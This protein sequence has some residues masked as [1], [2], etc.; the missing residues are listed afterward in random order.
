MKNWNIGN[1]LI[2]LIVLSSLIGLLLAI[3]LF[4][5]SLKDIEEHVY[6]DTI[7]HLN[8]TVSQRVEAKSKI[9]LSNAVSIA[10]DIGVINALKNKDREMAIEAM[11]HLSQKFKDNTPFKNI[12]VHIHDENGNSFLRSWAP[13]KFGDPLRDVRRT[14][15][16]VYTTKKALVGTEAGRLNT[17]L[18]G[19]APVTD[20]NGNYLGSIEFKAGFNSIIKSI[21]KFD[22]AH[23]LMLLNKETIKASFNDDKFK[24]LKQVHGMILNQKS[25]DE[26][27][28]NY[29][30]TLDFEQL[31]NNKYTLDDKYF[32]TFAPV[33]DYSGKTI[34]MYLIGEESQH[35]EEL[36]NQ[37]QSIVY[38]AIGLMFIILIIITLIIST[39]SRKIIINPL[40][41]LNKAIDNVKSNSSGSQRI[42]V[43]RN[44]EIGKVA[45]N[46]NSYLQMIEDGIKQDGKVIDEAIEIVHKAKEGFYTYQI[47]QK[48][49]SPQVDKL[50]V[51]V[52]E[53]LKVTSKNLELIITA[54]IQFGNA[55]YDYTINATSSG[56]I[57]SLIKGTNALGVSVSEVLNMV[58]NTAQRLSANAEQLAA[59]SEELSA[60]STEQAASLEETAAAIEQIT[61]TIVQ[62]DERTRKMLEIAHELQNTS[63][64]DDELA[65]KTGASMEEIDKATN[66]IV[67]AISII[68][69]IA[70]QT[71]ILSLNAAVEAATAG[72]AGKGFAVV[73]QEVRNLASRSAEAANDIKKLVTYAQEKTKE[74]K[75]TAD[76]MVESFN[77]LNEKVSEVTSNVQQVTEATHEQK[78]GMEQIN[79]AVN[80]LDK[81]TQENAN[82][83]EIV[84]NKAMALSEIS[85][86]LIAIV[87]R[88]SFDKSR[89]EG[90]CDVNLVFDT[91]KLKLDHISFKETN[92]KELGNGQT[93]KVKSHHECDL[94][95]WIEQHANE[96]YTQNSD[97]TNF[98]KAHE[99][100]HTG[101]QEFIHI[102]AKDRNDHR[103]YDLAHKIEDSTLKVFEGIDK[104]KAHKCKESQLERTRDIVSKESKNTMEYHNNV[105]KQKKEEVMHDRKVTAKKP[106]QKTSAPTEKQTTKPTLAKIQPIS[107]TKGDDDEW[108]SF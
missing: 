33:V 65:H 16:D 3:I 98:L 50:R 22:H 66:D 51:Q 37:S 100:V 34:G 46:F 71:N 69:Q 25:Y 101:V 96:S 26:T 84:S 53:M 107:Q 54:L 5:F 2:G 108:A 74:G 29:I 47:L 42:N 35:I 20:K 88:T 83:A 106:Y 90:V 1:K 38:T 97:W 87:N 102:D 27:F 86:Q 19:V 59:T 55:K 85:S 17:D 76:K 80:Q 30:E 67:E 4:T 60:S 70:F 94:G 77:F 36:V 45:N 104:I 58:N 41:E 12:K 7:E 8:A 75:S 10:N 78:L 82:A 44:D 56:N 32:V 68:D 57:G 92:F 79:S 21:K 93:A 63:N 24:Q 43:E 103:L 13:T 14:I 15:S 105:K 73:A 89:A 81:A 95:K 62:T 39:F 23:L 28:I 48:A 52:N 91:T 72:E 99:E 6:E 18:V 11:K 9:C 49:N 31:K 61:S 64:E 40:N